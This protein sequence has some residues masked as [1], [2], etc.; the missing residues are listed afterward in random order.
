MS[1]NV[2]RVA[3]FPAVICGVSLRNIAAVFTYL[4]GI[5]VTKSTIKRWIDDI[6]ENLPSEEE[7]LKK[8][9]D[10]KKA[11]RC[12][13]DACYP[14]GTDRC[15]TVVTDEHDR[16]LITHETD[17]ENADE[18]KKFPEKLREPGI[19]I[20]SAF[21]DYSESFIKAI[22]EVFPDAKF[23]ADHFHSVKN[24][25]DH[26]KK[27]LPEYRRNLKAAGEKEQDREMPEIASELRKL[28]WS[29]LKKPSDLSEEEREQTEAI[30]KKDGGFISEFR[31]VIRQIANISDHS[32]T[33]AR[34]EVRLKK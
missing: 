33:E 15:V 26:L 2:I 7:I 10:L 12:H 17:T 18:A 34:A 20:T 6:G 23:Q 31:S 24:I 32:D 4:F 19:N 21:S 28:R 30:E 25:W 22:K 3:C 9:T 29:L 13:T 14:L 8:L 11:S 16:I 5:P 27:G 1:R